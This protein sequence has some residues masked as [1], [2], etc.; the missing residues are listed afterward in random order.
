MKAGINNLCV[1]VALLFL[2]PAVFAVDRPV[3]GVYPTIQAAIDASVDGDTVVV[4]PNTYYERINF[5]GKSITVTSTDP[6]D[7]SVVAAT[8][9][10][11]S[12]S[13]TVVTFPDAASAN[14]L[15]AGFTVTNGNSSGSGGGIYCGNGTFTIN[16]CIIT[17]NSAS[18]GGGI[19]SDYA[20]LTV[21]GCT[22]SGNVANEPGHFNGGGGIFTHYGKSVLTNCTFSENMAPNS[23]GGGIRSIEGELILADCTFTSNSAAEEGGGVATDYKSV[24]VT[25]C[26]FSGNS[27]N[28]GGGMNNSHWGATAINCIFTGNS[29]QRGAGICTKDLRYGDQTLRLSN[30]TL[31]GNVADAYGGAVCYQHGGS[32]MLTDCIV[33]GNIANEGP[34]IAFEGGGTVS[35]SHSCL[36]G[37]QW[38]VYPPEAMQNW[39]NGSIE[40]DPRFV[41]GPVGDCYLGQIAAGQGSDSPCVDAGSDTAANLGMDVF[42]TRTDE[43]SDVGTVDMGYH[44]PAGTLSGRPDINLDLH[45]DSFDYCI[46]A[47]YWRQCNEPCDANYFPGDIIKD[48]CVDA[49]DLKVLADY[50][51]D[52]SV[53]TADTPTPPDS[54]AGA[55]PNLVL[56]WKAGY[57]SLLHDVYF[58]TDTNAVAQ[59]DHLSGEFMGTVPDVNFGPYTLKFDTKYCWRID[60][61]GP[62]CT[63]SGAV[64]SFTTDDGK[65]SEPDPAN[66]RTLVPP[67]NIL[68]WT[69]GLQASLHDVYFGT[70]YNDVN[71]ADTTDALVYKGEQSDSV[72]DPCGLA[73]AMTYYWRIDEKSSFGTVRGNVWSFTTAGEPNFHLVGWWQFDECTGGTAYDSAGSNHGTFRGDPNWV[74]GYV[75][76]C[77]LEFDGVD[78]YVRISPDSSLNLQYVTMSAW[79]QVR[80][81]G[82]GTNNHVLNR[83]MTK[84]GT[85]VLWVRASDDRM[86]GQV[87]LQGSESTG[88]T[89]MSNNAVSGE[90]THICA[91]YDGDKLKL[92]I[93]SVPQDDVDDTNGTMDTDNPGVFTIGAHPAPASYFDGSIDDVRLYNRA[94]STQEVQQLYQQ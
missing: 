38:D 18:N 69:P 27:A 13:G 10:D 30:C 45:V 11:A 74:S 23:S 65:A 48:H 39:P 28:W 85:Y 55:D 46:L 51:L 52:C 56:M 33:W 88:R 15:L 79:V 64:W 53:G 12:G 57:G 92:Y 67:D 61:A 21:T 31:S 75:G 84:P 40:A 34:Q 3:P 58:G 36:Q 22:F 47:A 16:N 77:A 37:G 7:P 5:G 73:D 8:V 91:T 93:D 94:L 20:G 76:S 43:V 41:T 24:T 19:Y 62:R 90:W 60:E 29:A 44:Y 81:T 70:D 80:G 6:N 71:D 87:R 63:Q 1:L 26:T 25:N 89:A 59:G 78:D 68:S 83:Q 32:L 2:N 17:G 66:G 14:C 72:W 4:E 54:S 9:I 42:T 82:P 49:N 35:V 50:W 86:G